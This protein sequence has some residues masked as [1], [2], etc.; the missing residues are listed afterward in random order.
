MIAVWNGRESRIRPA[1]EKETP[2]RG[3]GFFHGTKGATLFG[4]R[5]F[6]T[7]FFLLLGMGLLFGTQDAVLVGVH[8]VETGF[9]LG[10]V[11][12]LALLFSYNFV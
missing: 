2:R 8:L 4:R 7:L 1:W 6:R 11:E 10:L 3:A 5:L 9:G 12:L